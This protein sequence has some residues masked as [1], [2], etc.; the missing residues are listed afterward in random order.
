MG[1]VESR[2]VFSDA[3]YRLQIC[4]VILSHDLNRQV[5]KGSR[6]PRYMEQYT[7]ISKC[8]TY[9]FKPHDP[10]HPDDGGELWWPLT[11]EPI[12]VGYVMY[13]SGF[14]VAID[15]HEEEMAYELAAL[16][17]EMGF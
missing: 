12:M 1:S 5:H 3:Y 8:G 6:P 2:G 17:R 14:E 9:G 7:K 11:T 4:S 10:K 16:E 15:T 13:A